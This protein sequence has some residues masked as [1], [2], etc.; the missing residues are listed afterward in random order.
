MTNTQ[1][2]PDS[3]PELT[4]QRYG[5]SA[6][7]LHSGGC[8]ISLLLISW[9]YINSLPF[10]T[11]SYFLLSISVC[12]VIYGAIFLT[13]NKRLDRLILAIFIWA[14]IFRC[15]GQFSGPFL[16]DDPYRYLWDAFVFTHH[17]TPFGILPSDYFSDNSL[18]ENIDNILDHVSYPD[19]PTIYGPFSQWIFYLA[20]QIQPGSLLS[21]KLILLV[22]DVTCLYVLFRLLPGKWFLLFA[23][24][25][26]LIKEFSFSVHHDIIAI[27]LIV[28]ALY[29]CKYKR[30][31][32]VAFCLGLAVACKL[33]AVV[34]V[35]FIMRFLGIKPLTVFAI[36]VTAMYLPF[37]LMGGET[38][39]KGLFAFLQ[40]WEFNSSVY[41]LIA[42]W[43]GHA[44]A[45]KISLIL[46]GLGLLIVYRITIKNPA[47]YEA[48]ANTPRGDWAIG[49][50][51]LFSSVVNPWYVCWLL[52][53]AVFYSHTWPWIATLVMPLSYVVGLNIDGSNLPAYNH[54]AWVRPVIYTSILL[55]I[56]FDIFKHHK[57][58]KP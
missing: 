26:L 34:L 40:G 7:V 52:P 49:V 12:S 13:L 32:L 8:L 24:N 47:D 39:L 23:W 21:L 17:G 11:L 58:A 18:P 4:F 44:A 10:N 36:T 57:S 14:I 38:E 6:L 16:E 3:M 15:I 9:V 43:F 55:A 31:L 50:V 46:I 19:T 1:P 42:T 45:S 2:E 25:P 53:F 27:S 54:P 22:F 28:I 37:I 41:A 20:Y 48:N 33:L 29:A 51:L 56:C 30:Y 35:P 5:N